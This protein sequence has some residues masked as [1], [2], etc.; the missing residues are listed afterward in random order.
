[1]KKKQSAKSDAKP[2]R[3]NVT[4]SV[5]FCSTEIAEMQSYV[6][7]VKAATGYPLTRNQLI[8]KATLAHIR[9]KKDGSEPYEEVFKKI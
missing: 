6:D 2:Q 7:E 5:S 8:R 4:F 3:K 9:S 1:M